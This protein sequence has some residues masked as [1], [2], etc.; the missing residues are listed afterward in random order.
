MAMPTQNVFEVQSI[1]INEL[2]VRSAKPGENVQ[3][4]LVGAGVEDV[5]KGCVD[6]DMDTELYGLKIS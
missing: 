2:A 3:V 6:V 1:N 5:Q 4:K